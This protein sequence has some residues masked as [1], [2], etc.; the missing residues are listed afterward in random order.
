MHDYV[1]GPSAVCQL[2]HQPAA[3]L[4]YHQTMIYLTLLTCICAKAVSLSIFFPTTKTST[5][6]ANSR[7]LFL[8]YT[9]RGPDC[10]QQIQKVGLSVPARHLG[11]SISFMASAAVSQDPTDVGATIL[12]SVT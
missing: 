7:T 1:M 9:L 12:R 4:C 11:R 5:S 2:L 6:F 3:P 10:S 8:L